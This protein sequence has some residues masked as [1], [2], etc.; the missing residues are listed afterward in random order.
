MRGNG[1]HYSLPAD[2]EMP[3]PTIATIFFFF[4]SADSSLSS[5]RSNSGLRWEPDRR[6]R[7]SVVRG[8]GGLILRFLAGGGPSGA[9]VASIGITAGN[10]ETDEADDWGEG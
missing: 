4:R 7:C 9:V 5:C 3:A 10:D 2:V 1:V 6:S 8:L